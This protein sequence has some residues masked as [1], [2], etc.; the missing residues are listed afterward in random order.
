[1]AVKVSPQRA[2]AD[3]AK[4]QRSEQS[5]ALRLPVSIPVS[6]S[7]RLSLSLGPAVCSGR[8]IKYIAVVYIFCTGIAAL[9]RS[10]Y[11]HTLPRPASR[12]GLM[13][14]F[15]RQ[16]LQRSHLFAAQRIWRMHIM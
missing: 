5:R 8:R 10:T 3:T 14:T 9:A 11:V 16:P 13:M 4:P 7:L 1:M 15:F 6:I 2:N 12:P